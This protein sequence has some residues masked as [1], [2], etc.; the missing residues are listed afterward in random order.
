MNA[1]T[2]GPNLLHNAGGC[3]NKR[4]AYFAANHLVAEVEQAGNIP[5]CGWLRND[6]PC[7]IDAESSHNM[8]DLLRGM[9]LDCFNDVAC[10]PKPFVGP[11]KVAERYRKHWAVL[12]ACRKL[13][14]T[15]RSV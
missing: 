7:F 2:A 3:S 1:I 6:S 12:A 13:S 15:P 5:G 14:W 10:V 8:E 9:T 11:K 4:S